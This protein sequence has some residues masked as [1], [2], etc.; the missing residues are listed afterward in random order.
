MWKIEMNVNVKNISIVYLLWHFFDTIILIWY[1]NNNNTSN[2]EKQR[3]CQFSDFRVDFKSRR[4]DLEI[5]SKFMPT[6]LII[7]CL[8]Y[9]KKESYRFSFF[10][11]HVTSFWLIGDY[12]IL[13][14]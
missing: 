10:E 7:A 11:W 6:K 14:Y 4:S 5:A 12:N 9:W 3:K 13:M 8:F 1:V 2:N